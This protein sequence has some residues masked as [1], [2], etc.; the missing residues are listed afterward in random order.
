MEKNQKIN[1]DIST[2][3]NNNVQDCMCNL[4]CIKVCSQ[5]NFE[6]ENK[7]QTICQSYKCCE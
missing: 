6:V 5:G 3:V 2:C 7:E 4:E 1:C